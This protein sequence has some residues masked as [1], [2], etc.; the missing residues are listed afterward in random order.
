M[1][2]DDQVERGPQ[3]FVD[4]LDRALQRGVR[5]HQRG[6]FDPQ[7]RQRQQVPA[8]IHRQQSQQRLR[9]DKQVQHPV[10][11]FAR[12]MHPARAGL[13]RRCAAQQPP[14]QPRH[15]QPQHQR[16]GPFMDVHGQHARRRALAEVA[17][18][19]DGRIRQ[20]HQHE[21]RP[22]EAHRKPVIAARWRQHLRQARHRLY[23]LCALCGPVHVGSPSCST[24]AQRSAGGTDRF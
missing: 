1:Q 19:F 17:L 9:Q 11:G 12:Q 18:Q 20:R 2:P 14:Q 10:H 22:M 16:T 15:R 8:G 4:G 23:A 6:H 13:R 7:R 5:R 21:H 24:W 3:R